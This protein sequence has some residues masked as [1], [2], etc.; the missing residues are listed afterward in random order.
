MIYKH[1]GLLYTLLQSVIN[2]LQLITAN[3]GTVILSV[4]LF[5]CLSVCHTHACTIGYI[6]VVKHRMIRSMF[7]V[8]FPIFTRWRNALLARNRLMLLL[9]VCPSVRHKPVLYQNH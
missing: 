8:H 1:L 2:S 7:D 4:R 9:R 6:A 5:V 3:R